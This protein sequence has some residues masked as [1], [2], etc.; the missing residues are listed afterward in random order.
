[1]RYS[2]LVIQFYKPVISVTKVIVDSF[3]NAAFFG[4]QLPE[5]GVNDQGCLRWQLVC[6]LFLILSLTILIFLQFELCK[7]ITYLS[8]L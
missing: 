6:L 4:T 1:M 3:G 5:A 7:M 8:V 2:L